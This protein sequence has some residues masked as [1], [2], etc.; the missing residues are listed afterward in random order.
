[1]GQKCPMGHGAVLPHGLFASFST[2]TGPKSCKLHRQSPRICPQLLLAFGRVW[3]SAAKV[4][5]W[6]PHGD[7]AK[8]PHRMGLFCPMAFFA[9]SQQPLG[10]MLPNFRVRVLVCARNFYQ[11]IG[12]FGWR[13]RKLIFCPMGH[14][15]W[16][17]MPHGLFASFSI[18]TGPIV[19]KLRIWC[20]HMCPQLL[21]A[22][23]PI[24]TAISEDHF[25][26]PSAD[27]WLSPEKK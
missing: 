19:P 1:M 22:Y 11:H 6:L 4:S 10:Q 2:T 23:R 18:T 21:L 27:F 25:F 17:K 26:G 15:A 16:G 5:F 3:C 20:L 12:V 9:R 8:V 13:L 24:S 7:G 14:G